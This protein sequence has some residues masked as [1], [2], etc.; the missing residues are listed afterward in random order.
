V[1]DL[2]RHQGGV[3]RWATSYVAD[4]RTEEWDVELDDVVGTW[5]EDDDLISWFRA[6]HA[7]L[8]AALSDADPDLQCWTFLPSPS[9]LAMWA[10]RQAHETAIHRVDAEL[11]AGMTPTPPDPAFATDGVDE[12]LTCFVSGRSDRLRSEEPK[13]LVVRTDDTGAAWVLHVTPDSAQASAV[14]GTDAP[15]EADCQVSGS[16]ADLY[17]ALW[18]R[19]SPDGLTVAGDPAVLALFAEKVNIRWS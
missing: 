16:A 11:A 10:R 9:P 2:V 13:T 6:G 7:D 5:P 19:R 14:A 1:R 8:V 17:L 3:H 4:G 18:N 15:P 12:L